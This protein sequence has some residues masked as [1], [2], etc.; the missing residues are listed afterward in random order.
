MPLQWILARYNFE[1]STTPNRN[2]DTTIQIHRH[3]VRE[4]A[5]NTVSCVAVLVSDE[6]GR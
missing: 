6:I 5:G 2:I 1:D 4:A 3:S